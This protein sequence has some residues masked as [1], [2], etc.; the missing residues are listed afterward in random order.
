M[1]CETTGAITLTSG[2]QCAIAL[3]Q[4]EMLCEMTLTSGELQCAI[5][6]MQSE[7]PSKATVMEVRWNAKWL[8]T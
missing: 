6:L 3:M 2:E 1:P 5:A 8:A 7:M 4:S